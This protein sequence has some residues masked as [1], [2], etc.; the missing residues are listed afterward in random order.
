MII[1]TLNKTKNMSKLNQKLSFH[2]IVKL[3]I[4]KNYI[5]RVILTKKTRGI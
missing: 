1:D 2:T 5:I 3:G 4:T